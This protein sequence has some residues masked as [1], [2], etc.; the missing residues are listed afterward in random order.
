MKIKPAEWLQLSTEDK[1]K[2]IFAQ[3]I[4]AIIFSVNHEKR[5]EGVK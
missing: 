5:M 1:K 3:H 4:K 2:L